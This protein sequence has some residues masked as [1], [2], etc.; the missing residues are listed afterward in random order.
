[1][2]S[3]IG[4]LAKSLL[5][6]SGDELLR[7]TLKKLCRKVWTVDGSN[8]VGRYRPKTVLPEPVITKVLQVA[9]VLKDQDLIKDVADHHEGN[10]S[11][12]FFKWAQE[13]FAAGAV[14]FDSIKDR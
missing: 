13:Q 5:H 4:F 7:E 8:E 2:T 1:M 12:D 14:A 9:I 6:N 11:L 10:L 3:V